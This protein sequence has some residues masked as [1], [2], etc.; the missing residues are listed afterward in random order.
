MYVFPFRVLD[1]A[2]LT[3]TID[4][5]TSPISYTISGIGADSGWV[6]FATAPLPGTRIM[7]FRSVALMR[8][9]DY[10]D[11]GDLLA[12]TVNA[13]F[14]R[15]W[16][17][18]QGQGYLIGN[19]DP[20][21]SRALMLGRDDVNGSGAY[22][23][24]NNRIVSLGYP[25]SDTD[26]ATFGSA[27]DIAE[28]ITSGAQG[29]LGTFLQDGAG[30][31]VRTFQDKMR[32]TVSVKDYGP[33]N[34][35]GVWYATAFERASAKAG[36]LGQVTV[37]G[38]TFYLE[39]DVTSTSLF[40]FKS[41]ARLTGPGIL[42]APITVEG[43]EDST[44]RLGQLISKAQNGGQI[45]ASCYGDSLTYGQDTSP[46]GTG[47]PINGATQTRSSQPFPENLQLALTF[48]GFAKN[49]LVTNLGFPGDS[50]RE[51]LI[52]WHN[53]SGTDVAIIM[54]GHNDANNYGG[55]GVVP[56]DEYARNLSMIAVREI[57]KGAAVIILGPPPNMWP[58]GDNNIR[59]YAQVAQ[60]VAARF[61]CIFVDTADIL[62]TVTDLYTDGTHLTPTAYAEIGFQLATLFMKRDGGM[63]KVSPM[64]MY[65]PN[66]G[67]G[68]GG[69]NSN[70]NWTGGKGSDRLIQLAAGESYLVAVDVQA[71][72]FPVIHSYR[73]SGSHQMGVYYAGGGVVSRGQPQATVVHD[74]AIAVR[75]TLICPELK[76][77]KRFFMVRNDAAGQAFIEAIEFVGREHL[78]VTRGALMKSAAL[79]GSAQT[80]RLSAA[81]SNWWTCGDFTR[82][83]RAPY[84]VVANLKLTDTVQNGV[85]IWRDLPA[86]GEI[87]CPNAIFV[88][89]AGT[90]LVIR[91]FVNGSGLDT[92]IPGVFG[93][94]D[95]TG[96]IE[97]DVSIGSIDVYVNGALVGSRANP[98]ATVGYPGLLADKT[99]R[100]VCNA[101]YFSGHVKGPY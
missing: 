101:F 38:E 40:V 39:R 21:S 62:S 67:L 98:T 81:N 88:L 66:D 91:D 83:L 44:K 86:S 24:N 74:A 82:K 9:E 68:W 49:I 16:M 31:V 2:D 20:V 23:A 92:Y 65:Y 75:Q 3:V 72:V 100:V 48:S 93:A 41:G 36:A 30:A 70:G 28:K 42:Y 59:P 64:E 78:H 77:G 26:A 95:W 63:K 76:K 54:Y 5:V 71:D 6:T 53:A 85:A 37:P 33:R 55:N 79:S 43:I 61:N 45:Y 15:I 56:I 34:D 87:L 97:V 22:R 73:T 13:D 14:D 58:D 99:A 90:Q 1:P 60:R 46:T 47:A 7:L 84:S 4:G 8:S 25:V 52:R 12:D 32:E 50:T 29:A 35:V 27:R 17:A 69:T 19:G 94:G 80:L 57:W 96:E 18:L 10:Q 51:G 11:N 89:R